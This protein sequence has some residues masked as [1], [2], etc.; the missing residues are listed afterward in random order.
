MWGINLTLAQRTIDDLTVLCRANLL[1]HETVVS[2]HG[3]TAQVRKPHA[4]LALALIFSAFSLGSV[5]ATAED[6]HVT[7]VYDPEFGTV[8]D[9]R[10]N[11]NG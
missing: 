11:V 7:E 2:T 9:Y 6:S 1:L 10:C 5:W 4:L 8:R 3:T